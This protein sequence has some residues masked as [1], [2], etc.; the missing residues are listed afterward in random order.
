[1]EEW[2]VAVILVV[3]SLVII[4]AVAFTCRVLGI[5]R[6][7]SLFASNEEKTSL[8]KNDRTQHHQAGGGYMVASDD[9]LQ[10]DASGKLVQ[11]DTLGTDPRYTHLG[12]SGSTT[13]SGVHTGLAEAPAIIAS[14]PSPTEEKISPVSLD[15]MSIASDYEPPSGLQ[16]AMSCESVA[17]DSSVMDYELDAPKI[18]QL[19][20]GLEYDREVSELIISVIRARDLEPNEVTRSLDSYVKLWLSPSR[21]GKVVTKV[22]KDTTEPVYKERFLFNVEPAELDN[23]TA[24]FQVY[25]SDKY[26]R[27]KLLGET[28]LR[29]GDIDFRQPMRIWMNLRDMDEKPTDHGDVMFSLSYLPTAERLTVVVVKARNLKW[30]NNMEAGDCFVKVYLLQNG[31]K[32]S[33]KKTSVKRREKNPIFNEAMIFSVPAQSLQTVQLRV[34]VI[35]D[36][37]EE[38]LTSLGHVIVGSQLT[39]TEL[40]HWNQM[41]TSLRK[42]VAMWHSLRK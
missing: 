3:I 41:M 7:Q 32:M 42:P 15:T 14:Y 4:L 9:G 28:D 12:E 21:E 13:D 25:S 19:E 34:T 8:T 33:K 35:E 26:A 31:K 11:Y 36:V 40:T 29:L 18:G 23:K 38:R 39:G 22:Q 5:W 30:A 2:A 10:L 20:F 37:G 27:N 6:I 16:R 17:S 24:Q 1:M